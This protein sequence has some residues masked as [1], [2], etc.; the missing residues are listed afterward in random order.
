MKKS[1]DLLQWSSYNLNRQ[2]MVV[3]SARGW[4]PKDV[5]YIRDPA[6]R[7]RKE[8]AGSSCVSLYTQCCFQLADKH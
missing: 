8:N 3:R 5:F 2:S 4:I 6:E 1:R 7:S